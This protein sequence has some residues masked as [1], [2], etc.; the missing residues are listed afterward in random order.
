MNNFYP[1][2]TSTIL[3]QLILVIILLKRGKNTPLF[4][5]F[6]IFSISKLI[7]SVL[8]I[9]SAFAINSSYPIFHI[10]LFAEFLL[11]LYLFNNIQRT[12][13]FSISI[14]FFGLICFFYESIFLNKW[15]ENNEIFTVYFNLSVGILSLKYLFDFIYSTLNQNK[16][17]LSFLFGFIFIKCA[18]SIILSLFE[19]DIRMEPNDLAVFLL[20]FYNGFEIL[21]G[22]LESRIVWKLK[23]A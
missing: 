4:F 12:K 9:V 5:P 19:S 22:L 1:I 10:S 13:I 3:S 16:K 2:I 6:L 21:Q 14:L 17:L 20:Y 8:T 7:F 15:W 11:I 18:S 23:E